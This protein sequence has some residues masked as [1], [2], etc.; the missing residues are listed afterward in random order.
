MSKLR[1]INTR[2]WEDNWIVDCDPSEK[3]LFLYLLTNTMTNML[4][5]YEIPLRRIAFDTGLDKDMILKLFSRFEKDGKAFYKDG[6]VV[7]LNY[8]K[9]QNYNLNM[10]K[11]AYKCFK[12]LKDSL[13][14]DNRVIEIALYLS[15]YYKPFGKGIEPI[16]KGSKPFAKYEYELEVEYEL[17]DEVECD[18]KKENRPSSSSTTDSIKVFQKDKDQL[19]SEVDKFKNNR[20]AKIQDLADQYLRDPVL[21][22]LIC[23]RYSIDKGLLEDWVNEFVQERISHGEP[24]K[25]YK[26]FQSHFANWLK[27]QDLDNHPRDR[28]FNSKQKNRTPTGTKKNGADLYAE[29]LMKQMEENQSYS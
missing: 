26:D 2:F 24:R 17:E 1:S 13:L 18:S 6:H 22:D 5:I 9:H 7:L 12:E 19:T 11:S 20:P 4:G 28:L 15:D 14:Q 29:K 21:T 8:T 3:L 27:Y 10:Y 25:L 16:A 23:K